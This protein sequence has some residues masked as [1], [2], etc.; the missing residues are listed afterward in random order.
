M[1]WWDKFSCNFKYIFINEICFIKKICTSCRAN[2]KKVE[3]Y[4]VGWGFVGP[5]GVGWGEKVFIVMRDG[6]GQGWRQWPHLLAP[7]P[8]VAISNSGYLPHYPFPQ[9]LKKKILIMVRE[10]F[11]KR[12][13]SQRCVWG[14][15]HFLYSSLFIFNIFF[16]RISS[17]IYFFGVKIS[18]F[19]YKSNEGNVSIV[20]HSSLGY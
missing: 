2:L 5:R 16:L 18:Y 11:I 10:L 9:Q 8:S 17:L 13:D 7:L 3:F 4:R 20:G 19:I 1:I 14:R 15:H 12:H 6:A